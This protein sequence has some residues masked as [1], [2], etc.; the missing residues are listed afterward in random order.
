MTIQA[1][2]SELSVMLVSVLVFTSILGLGI[3]VTT[4]QEEPPAIPSA[5]YGE[6]KI[7]DA[8]AEVG[9]TVEAEID[10]EVRGSIDV[11]EQGQYGCFEGG[12]ERLTVSGSSA[13]PDN[14]EVTLYIDGDDFSRTEVENTTPDPVIWE[15]QIVTQV[16]L[17]VSVE[18]EPP[19]E[20][21]DANGDDDGDVNGD[22]DSGGAGG[23]GGGSA[24]TGDDDTADDPDTSD[25]DAFS[26]ED[27]SETVDATE[28]DNSV[29]VSATADDD[30]NPDEEG[31][32][33]D[34]SQDTENVD[35]ITFDDGV[36]SVTVEE[37]SNKNV[38]DT[39]A[40]SIQQQISEELAADI[41][42]DGDE[43]VTDGVEADVEDVGD[44][45]DTTAGT[46]D[47]SVSVN[48][49]SRITADDAEFVPSRVTISAPTDEVDDSES[50]SIFRE[51]ENGWEELDTNV[52][53]EDD[54][55]VRFAGQPEDNSLF[56][57]AEVRVEEQKEDDE[58]VEEPEAT[59]DSIPG[60]GVVVAVIATIALVILTRDNHA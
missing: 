3:P 22:D 4:A 53:E 56:A 5:Y 26:V 28:P 49:V 9:V 16:D 33:V 51:A 14:P 11:T 35:D 36:G 23:G 48:S 7:N 10:G 29:E 8:P 6:V 44:V 25:A 57:V 31:I 32:T 2:R 60:F 34:T 38:L 39:T 21:D 50:V 40:Q 27:V 20:G 43:E 54:E 55:R 12:G 52:V 47:V 30:A 17:D 37:F 15:S 42:E 58:P 24:P 59:D 13:D 18:R 45:A 1:S 46:T 19:D 41:E